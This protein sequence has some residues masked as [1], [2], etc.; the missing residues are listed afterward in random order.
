MLSFKGEMLLTPHPTPKLQDHP[1]L[2]VS[3]C[4]FNI[5]TATSI[6]GGCLLHL[7]S[8]DST[9]HGDTDSDYFSTSGK[10]NYNFYSYNF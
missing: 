5:F 6:S 2:A 3:D 7:Q 1:L 9:R 4:L 10:Y 8:E